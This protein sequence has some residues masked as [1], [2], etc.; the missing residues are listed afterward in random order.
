MTTQR[1]A[2]VPPTQVETWPVMA[3]E[4]DQRR[5]L[6][7]TSRHLLRDGLP[8]I[9]VSGEIH[10]TRMPRTQWKPA[11]ELMKAGGITVVSAYVFWIHHQERRDVAPDFTGDRDLAAFVALCAELGLEMII[12]VGPWCHGEVRNGGLPDWVV[13][14]DYRERTDDPAYLADVRT[15]LSHLGRELAPLCGDHGPIIG[16]QVENELYDQREHIVTLKSIIRASGLVAP[17]WTATAWGSADI[18]VGEVFPLYGGYADGFW[19]D[20]DAGWDDS[21]RSHYRFSHQ[22]DD[23][24]IGKDLAGAAWSGVVGA[25]HPDF[26]A[27]TCELGGGMATAYHRRP[28]LSGA[29][30]AAVAQ[31]KLGSGS[32]W[33]GYYM[34]AGGINPRGLTTLQESHATGYPNDLPVH[35]YDFHAPVGAHLQVRDSYHR[36]RNQ[37][38]FLTAFGDRLAPMTAT[39]PES[40]VDDLRWCLRSDGTSGFVY[41]NNHQ[42]YEPLPDRREVQFEVGLDDTTVTF[43]TEPVD[44]ASGVFTVWPVHFQVAGVLMTWATATPLTLLP[45]TGVTLP[46]LVLAATEGVPVQL[47]FPVTYE[48]LGALTQI[49]P[50]ELVATVAPGTAIVTVRSPEG[51]ALSVLVLDPQQAGDAWTPHV[52]GHR[53]LVLSAAAVVER[54]GALVAMTEEAATIQVFDPVTSDFRSETV[55]APEPVA[56][57]VRRTRDATTPPPA[58]VVVPGRASAPSVAQMEEHA[59]RFVV[60]IGPG[61]VRGQ[62]ALLRVDL[63]GDVAVATVGDRTVDVFWDGSTW[64]VDV[65]LGE[66]PDV[67]EVMIMVYPLTPETPVWLP[68][69]AREIQQGLQAPTA[70]I[71]SVEVVTTRTAV[72]SLL[73]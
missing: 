21:F 4:Q 42:P 39:I 67:D 71:V 30:I 43:P 69:W 22:W 62:R 26:P 9:P 63:V 37:H 13:A 1:I 58:T 33:Q 57:L 49:T 34:Y 2:H 12:R 11:L 38:S 24:G 32:V 55:A 16:V 68:S 35:D 31:V 15:Y 20:T 14:A 7:L 60:T 41:V 6:S 66:G 47:S 10:F 73:D 54:D 72:L 40:G 48:V 59:A 17:L 5:G 64:D 70:E 18:P 65:S 56:A 25:K 46:V 44:L 45:A 29:D 28:V 61:R 36:L 53:R 52:S 19:V 50:T 27:A 51:G 8:W 23:P 3:N